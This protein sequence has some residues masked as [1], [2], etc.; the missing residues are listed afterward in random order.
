M[1]LLVDWRR[2]F[3][4]LPVVPTA[5]SAFAPSHS[6]A[7]AA[8]VMPAV[9][10]EMGRALS[11]LPP[12][13]RQPHV[14]AA[15]LSVLEDLT[16]GGGL[17]ADTPLME[18]G[19]DSLGA[20]EAVSRLREATGADLAPTL[21]F[22]QPSAR[23]IAAH[24]VGRLSGT[25]AQAA[26]EAASFDSLLSARRQPGVT[27]FMLAKEQRDS[28][29]SREDKH[30]LWQTLQGDRR[31]E[32]VA[33]WSWRN[34][35]PGSGITRGGAV[36]HLGDELNGNVHLIHGGFTA[37]LLDTLFGWIAITEREAQGLPS[38]ALAF[39]ANL[40]VNYR[41]PMTDRAAYYV[42]LEAES[43][44]KG[45]EV[46]LKATI[47]DAQGRVVADGTSLFIV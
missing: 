18:A 45:K 30:M 43:F 47:F 28:L 40:N 32:K 11:R 17:T 16:G 4:V 25:E 5:L 24:V 22:D 37:A 31:L 35:S 39:T 10:S 27:D 12:A 20:T 13:A 46:Y 36:V 6:A 2:F 33:M 41:M 19:I 3:G 29:A 34:S 42:E 23:A 38:N 15:V 21:F 1:L 7:A 26:L 9:E 44:E 8:A 14:E